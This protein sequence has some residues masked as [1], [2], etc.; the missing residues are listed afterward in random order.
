MIKLT[1]EQ[2]HEGLINFGNHIKD[3][4]TELDMSVH[5][6]LLLMSEWRQND[7]LRNEALGIKLKPVT[8]LKPANT[9]LFTRIKTLEQE[10]KDA[11]KERDFTKASILSA[12]IVALRKML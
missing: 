9:P 7:M 3:I 12:E 11:E 2:Y 6:T 1:P 4:A 10:V 5:D 8:T